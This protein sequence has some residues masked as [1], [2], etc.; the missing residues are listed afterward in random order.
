M[1][2]FEKI[3]YKNFLSTGDR[4]NTI[5][6]NEYRNTLIVG[7]NGAGKSTLLDAICFALYGK[8]FRDINKPNL[9]NSI[10]KKDL[11]VEIYLSTGGSRYKIIR[12]IKP[13]I[14]EIYKND[15]LIDQDGKNIQYQEL[16][17]KQILKMN[18]KSFCQN[19][20][21][22]SAGFTPFMRLKAQDRREII[23][24]ILDIQIISK[25]NI[26]HKQEIQ[27][28]LDMIE[29]L[30]LNIKII[31]E[32]IDIQKKHLENRI[33]D[34]QERISLLKE[35]N[36][37]DFSTKDTI[38]KEIQLLEADITELSNEL[39]NETKTRNTYYKI[40]SLSDQ[41][42]F[43]I[44]KCEEEHSF[45]S[46]THE[47]PTCLQAIDETFA[48][49]KVA[50]INEDLEKQ[51]KGLDAL[52]EKLATT[53][54]TLD[55]MNSIS[56]K[57]SYKN[58][59]LITKNNNLKWLDTNI[60]HRLS[61]ISEIERIIEETKDETFENFSI[62]KSELIK[63]IEQEY[64]Q[65]EIYREATILLKDSGYKAKIIKQ[66]IP[67]INKYINKYLSSMNFFVQFELDENFNEIIRSRFRDDFS[68]ESFS[69]GERLRIDIAIL[70]TW[71]AIS[72]MRNSVATN[73]LIM[74]EVFDSSLDDSGTDDFLKIIQSLTNETNTFII[75]HNNVMFD[76][77]ENVIE[78]EKV[79]SFSQMK[80]GD[81]NDK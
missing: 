26:L 16:L 14:F 4:F 35:E 81:I 47:C 6:L 79:K 11:I 41:I 32:K 52:K 8:S 76:K 61:K 34:Q 74:D 73:L 68:Y 10:N 1:I 55:R 28:S 12:G 21:L 37:I 64:A 62:E 27:N 80:N 13:N 7:T 42:K 56:K 15:V 78:F 51:H 5:I 69:Q 31:D 29:N 49:H 54:S 70:F 38:M 20:I 45:F 22:G 77:F 24:D 19:V 30:N 25:M 71:R 17:E 63:K 75:S 23:E 65:Q 18:F 57:I 44:T 46:E 33:Q 72:K 58:S 43:N 59:E 48:Q 36:I 66:Y 67:I 50:M 40:L 53:K 60:K 2:V 3:K 9:V 39:L